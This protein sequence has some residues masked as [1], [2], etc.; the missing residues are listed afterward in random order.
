M[1]KK[2]L[3]GHAEGNCREHVLAIYETLHILSGKWKIAIIGSLRFGKKRFMELQRDVEG[4]GPKMLSKELHELEK[5]GLIKRTVY[6]TRPIT[7]DYDMTDYGKTLQTIIKEMADW[8][9]K[10]RLKTQQTSLDHHPA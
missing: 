1:D 8:G 10:H 5:N 3:C 6:D 7:V 9:V 2:K 4:I